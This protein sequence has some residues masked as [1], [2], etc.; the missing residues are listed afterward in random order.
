M[1]RLNDQAVLTTLLDAD[2]PL[3]ATRL[4]AAT[5]LSRTT[6]E[7]VLA[8][9]VERGTIIA[10]QL[11]TVRAGRPARGYRFDAGRGVS[12]GIDVGPH[13]IAGIAGDLRGDPAA[14]YRRVELDLAG[15]DDAGAAIIK[16]SSTLLRES[17]TSSHELAAL[18]VGIPAVVDADGRPVKTTVVPEWLSA[19]LAIHLHRAFPGAR[20]S[21]DNDTKLAAA[22]ELQN[23]TVRAD[24]TAVVVRIGNRISAATI[25]DGRVARGANGSAGEIG[26]LDRVAWPEAHQRLAARA[27]DGVAQLFARSADRSPADAEAIAD[28]ASDIADGLA[29]LVLAI[30]PHAVIVTSSIP[31]AS[32]QLADAL[33]AELAGRTL[34]LPEFRASSLGVSA[35]SVG[36][37]AVSA[38]NIRESFFSAQ[39]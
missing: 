23:G 35:P 38:A 8:G 22:A 12:I 32:A 6:V 10:E 2:E 18:T 28:F 9:M 30:D 19:D 13:G 31:G 17:T 7:T 5:S 26:A 24:E 39:A 21:F 27:P 25:I 29:A 36:A 11:P 1:R 20:I 15:S 4:A 16:L 33:E 34:F 37:L 14:A 3:T